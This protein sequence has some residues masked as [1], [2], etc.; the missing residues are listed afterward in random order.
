MKDYA[1]ASILGAFRA[2]ILMPIEQPLD[3]LKTQI[4]S[5]LYRGPTITFIVSHIKTHGF[6]K[7][8]TGLI[9]NTI[10]TSIKQAYRLP[11]MVAIPNFY[12]KFVSNENIIQICTG[13][14]LAT[15]ESYI[16][17]PL[18][19]VKIWL[20]TAP[21]PTFRAFIEERAG[22][23]DFYKGVNALLMRQTLSWVT[24]LG[25]TSFFKESVIRYKGQV[26]FSDL[27]AIGIIVGAI[28]TTI[29]MP[30]DFI[31]THKQ[32]FGDL[33]GKTL[34]NSFRFLTSGEKNCYSKFLIVY[35]GWRI[36]V[37]HYFIN[38]VA[39]VNLVDH[40]ERKFSTR[41]NKDS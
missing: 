7:L 33:S 20:M 9:P 19:R 34:L 4:Q 3:Y 18:E 21:K 1:Y 37:F 32:K 14:T 17:C 41:F 31:K 39:T 36:R 16:I 2:S 40:L 38:C 26:E 13:I 25:F 23:G 35:C 27:V 29:I 5:Q 30:A 6:L 24:F 11:L 15:A 12:R 22:L 8:Y 10:R 28:N